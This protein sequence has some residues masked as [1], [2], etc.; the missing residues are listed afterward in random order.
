MVAKFSLQPLPQRENFLRPDGGALESE[1]MGPFSM[2]LLLVSHLRHFYPWRPRLC[3]YLKSSHIC[4]TQINNQVVYSC[5]RGEDSN[6]NGTEGLLIWEV[7]GFP[8]GDTV[9]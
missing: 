5:W 8:S 4:V 7:G 9:D 1:E 6:G 2:K 3:D